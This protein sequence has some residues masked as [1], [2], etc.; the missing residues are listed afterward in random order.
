LRTVGLVFFF[1]APIALVL[2][3]LMGRPVPDVVGASITLLM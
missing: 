3:P 1:L 2:L